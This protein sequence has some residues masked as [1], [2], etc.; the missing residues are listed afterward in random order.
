MTR[1]TRTEYVDKPQPNLN[2]TVDTDDDDYG[3]YDDDENLQMSHRIVNE[4][5]LMSLA[6][7]VHY[8]Y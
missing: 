2:E 7:Y 6:V 3:D 1:L 8:G 5:Y 4:D